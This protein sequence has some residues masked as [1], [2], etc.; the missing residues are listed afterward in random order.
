MPIEGVVGG[1]EASIGKPPCRRPR[2]GVEDL[3]G[4]NVPADRLGRAAPEVRRVDQ[5]G[6]V[7]G[8]VLLLRV[9]PYDSLPRIDTRLDRS[10]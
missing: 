3:S 5:A 7:G 1:V 8:P 2:R 6:L 4:R 10:A 9:Q